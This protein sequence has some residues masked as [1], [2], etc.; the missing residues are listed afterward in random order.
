[1][2]QVDLQNLKRVSDRIFGYLPKPVDGM[3]YM[4]GENE[5]KAEVKTYNY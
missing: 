4:V 2:N 1:M 5:D 3:I